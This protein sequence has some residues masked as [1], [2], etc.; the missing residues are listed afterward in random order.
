[1]ILSKYPGFIAVTALRS[2]SI[3]YK[4]LL[5]IRAGTSSPCCQIP[6]FAGVVGDLGL[7]KGSKLLT[8]TTNPKKSDIRFRKGSQ[9]CGSKLRIFQ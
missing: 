2:G 7:S 4:P 9:G 1:M 8:R 5:M 3:L 6:D